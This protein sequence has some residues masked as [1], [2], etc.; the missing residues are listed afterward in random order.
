M[1]V[2]AFVVPC[3]L[4]LTA[5]PGVHAQLPAGS[6][7]GVITTGQRITPAGMQTA[8]CVRPGNPPQEPGEHWKISSFAEI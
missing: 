3:V 1:P 6:A 7:Q 8:L 5:W 2:K 4:A